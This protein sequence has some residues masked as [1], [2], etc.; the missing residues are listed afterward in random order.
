MSV[1][2][3][4]SDLLDVQVQ[5]DHKNSGN[6]IGPSTERTHQNT[7]GTSKFPSSMLRSNVQI[8]NYP[9]CESNAKKYSHS[10]PRLH[11]TRNVEYVTDFVDLNSDHD[12]IQT[13]DISSTTHAHKNRKRITSQD[14][15]EVTVSERRSVNQATECQQNKRH[16]VSHVAANPLDPP[17][18]FQCY[19]IKLLCKRYSSAQ[20]TTLADNNVYNSRNISKMIKASVTEQK[21]DFNSMPW[22]SGKEPL[23]R[24]IC[25]LKPNDFGKKYC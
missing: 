5:S 22:Y 13:N 11:N 17:F 12:S 2:P 16:K 3:T 7:A 15:D 18:S 25:H 10:V 1:D 9:V 8:E 21:H 14:C 23:A 24:V 6:A 19:F 4:N 20:S